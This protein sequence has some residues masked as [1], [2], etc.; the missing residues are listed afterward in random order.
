MLEESCAKWQT[1]RRHARAFQRLSGPVLKVLE[2]TA[3]NTVS[4]STEADSLG[5]YDPP[6]GAATQSIGINWDSDLFDFTIDP[7][8]MTDVSCSDTDFLELL[9]MDIF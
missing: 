8:A 7:S 9:G 2:T 6:P 5:N 4:T 3:Q 1:V